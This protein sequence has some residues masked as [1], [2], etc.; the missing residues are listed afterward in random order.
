MLLTG[1]P[2]ALGDYTGAAAI[3]QAFFP[4][5]LGGR[6]VAEVLT[7]AVS[8]SGRLPVSVPR[9][10]GSQPGTYLSV[11]LGR[12]SGVSNLD[13]TP[14]FPFGHG[15]G[16]ATFA[17]DDVHLVSPTAGPGAEGSAAWPVDGEATVELTVQNTGPVAGADIVQV[18][19]HDPVAQVV[20]PI[21]SLV[22]FA[23]VELDPGERARVRFTIPA[24]LASF[25][26][27]RGTRVVEPGA[28]ELRVARSSTDVHTALAL[29]LVGVECEVGHD[30]RL[31]S[32]VEIRKEQR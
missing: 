9:N 2:Y 17:W 19:L 25:T 16:Y 6:A 23:R 5:Q 11:P 15:L 10:P 28:V 22:A 20:R 7:G 32:D 8:P 21:D 13:P 4:G 30:R 26:G 18:Y 12:R 24:D 1:R 27:L 31:T 29:E 3:V 14:A